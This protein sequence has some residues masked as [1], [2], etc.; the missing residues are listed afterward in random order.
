MPSKAKPSFTPPQW[1]TKNVRGF[2]PIQPA[3]IKPGAEV[4]YVPDHVETIH[5]IE[6]GGVERG[7]IT[8]HSP[9]KKKVWC[10]FFHHDRWELRT[11]ANSEQV[12][13]GDLCWWT[14]LGQE[15]IKE[16][17]KEFGLRVTF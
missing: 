8:M 15:K 17:M 9:D 14:Q 1:S 10:R 2:V 11:I 16:I 7:F 3:Y 13:P 4:L 5:Q 12:S 6:P